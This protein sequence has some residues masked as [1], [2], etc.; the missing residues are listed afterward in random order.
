MYNEVVE[1]LFEISE[2][3]S[4]IDDADTRTITFIG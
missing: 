1:E 3:L 2:K 4:N